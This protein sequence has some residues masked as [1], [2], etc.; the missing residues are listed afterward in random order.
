MNYPGEQLP[1]SPAR[2]SSDPDSDASLV[3]LLLDALQPFADACRQIDGEYALLEHTYGPDKVRRPPPDALSFAFT[4]ETL[5]SALL[6]FDAYKTHPWSR[7]DVRCDG[8]RP[9][10]PAAS[11]SSIRK[12]SSTCTRTPSGSARALSLGASSITMTIVEPTEFSPA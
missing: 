11:D 4:Y 7:G 2:L 12:H 3:A 10:T 5:Q 6:A 8:E 1:V 9:T